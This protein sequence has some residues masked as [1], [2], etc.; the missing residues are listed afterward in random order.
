MRAAVFLDRDGT[1]IEDEG[2]L[3]DASRVR[4]LAGAVDALQTFRERGL[5]LVLISNQS[6]IARGLITP[7]Q[8][9]EVH[10]RVQHVL[11]VEGLALGGAYY[12]PH[13]PD[14]GCACRKPKPGMLQQA[15]RDLGVDLTRSF[16]VGDKMSDVAAGRAAGCITALLGNGKDAGTANVGPGALPHHRGDDWLTLLLSMET[17][18]KS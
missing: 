9:G 15:A 18:W 13:G 10:A 4:L 1:I 7:A 5:L 8:H 2:Y 14:D 17:S 12:C 3:A 16:M 6:G 11:A